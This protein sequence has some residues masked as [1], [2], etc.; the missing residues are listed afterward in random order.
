M[1]K[2][3]SI[4]SFRPGTGKSAVAANI[5]TV[6]AAS[7]LRVGII[8]SDAQSPQIHALF[9]VPAAAIQHSL[10]DFMWGSCT[11]TQTAHDISHFIS[12]RLKGTIFLI[13]FT[14]RPDDI[15][16]DISLLSDS[17]QLLT[18]ALSLDVLLID[19]PPGL[20]NTTLPTLAF[21][22]LQLVILR[23]DDQ[24]FLG[25]S[26]TIDVAQRLGVPAMMLIVTQVPESLDIA[27]VRQQVERA[28]GCEVIAVLAESAELP[29]LA[30]PGLFVA[31]YPNHPI[32]IEL[33]RVAAVLTA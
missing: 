7:G 29:A 24:D 1:A 32:T 3:V 11:I 28:Y 33:T 16:Y 10:N 22:D 4:H 17:F 30:R 8:D 19:T 13:P 26:V 31:Y 15:D 18:R 27:G 23:P 14:T 2:I 20:D 12:D 25:T 9:G 21:S 5:A 6:L